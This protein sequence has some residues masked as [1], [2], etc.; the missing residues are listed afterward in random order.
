MPSPPSAS[1]RMARLVGAAALC[2]CHT[3][4]IS[5]PAGEIVVVRV[6]GE[7]DLS[8]TQRE[9]DSFAQDL[10]A[11]VADEHVLRT[12][13]GEARRRRPD[14][15]VVDVAGMGFCSAQG[16]ALLVGAVTE[17][18]ENGVRYL[19]CGV[20][21]DIERVLKVL[22]PGTRPVCHPT[23]AAAVLAAMVDQRDRLNRERPAP[24]PV[25]PGAGPRLRAVECADRF[26]GLTDDEITERARRSD[27][28]AFR[29]LARRHRTRMYR[30][31][32]RV[33]ESSKD[34]EDVAQDIATNLRLALAAFQEATPP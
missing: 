32:L 4:S 5:T 3:T 9:A 21:P 22:W 19:L 28:D 13:L 7:I 2:S 16:L 29:E 15:L 14:H 23:V 8:T 27:S 25:P 6:F 26:G 20:D 31:A 1:S 24:H 34:P 17:P 30:S 12:A 33:L 18:D 10:R 11:W